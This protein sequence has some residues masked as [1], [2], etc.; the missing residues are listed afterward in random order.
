M[1]G[2]KKPGRKMLLDWWVK[3][4]NKNGL[5]T[6]KEDDRRQNWMALINTRPPHSRIP[7]E[8]ERLLADTDKCF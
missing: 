3:K 5:F 4:K 2:R 7:V 8:E 1:K 6:A